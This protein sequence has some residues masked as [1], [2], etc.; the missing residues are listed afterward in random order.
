MTEEM[1][2]KMQAKMQRLM[3]ALTKEAARFS[4]ADFLENLDISDEDYEAIKEE[5]KT[6][7]GVTPY[8]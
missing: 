2:A 7:L 3:R 6:K 8:V 1:Q 5:W 4:Y